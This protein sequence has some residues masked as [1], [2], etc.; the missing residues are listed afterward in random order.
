MYIYIYICIIYTHTYVGSAE[1][2]Y[3]LKQA[4]PT[5]APRERRCV[6]PLSAGCSGVHRGQ[7]EHKR[8]FRGYPNKRWRGVLLTLVSCC[9][10]SL[11]DLPP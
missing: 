4:T 2:L 8:S 3:N 10:R 1:E 7:R 6:T 11:R 9:P 5:Q